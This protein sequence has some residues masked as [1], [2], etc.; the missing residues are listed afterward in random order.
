M[1]LSILFVLACSALTITAQSLGADFDRFVNEHRDLSF[2]LTLENISPAGT[3]PGCVIASPSKHT[4]PYYFHWVRDGALVMDS[5]LVA[6]E[7]TTDRARA[8]LLEKTLWDFVGMTRKIQSVKTLA[9]SDYDPLG[10]ADAKYNVDGSAY[11]GDWGRP[12]HDGPALRASS[13][14]RFAQEY[15]RRGGSID[16]VRNE[17]YRPALPADTPIKTDLELTTRALGKPNFDLWEEIMGQHFYTTIA[18]RRALLTGAKFA[19][20]MNDGGAGDWY[21]TK[22]KQ[23]DAELNAY[24][25]EERKY[26]IATR[27]FTEEYGRKK[28]ASNLDVAVMLGVLHSY[29]DVTDDFFAPDNDRVLAT[30]LRL[31]QAHR[32]EFPINTRYRPDLPPAIGRYTEDVYDGTENKGTKGNPWFLTTIGAA[33]LHYRI[34]TRAARRGSIAIS[35]LALPFYQD[36]LAGSE[37]KPQAGTF[38]KGSQEFNA[39]TRG[40]VRMGDLYLE[41]VRVHL[42][43]DRRMAEQLHRDTGFQLS[44][45]DLTWNYASFLTASYARD[46]ARVAYPGAF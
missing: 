12:Q 41:R 10:I 25:D 27:D 5:L 18:Q 45:S 40:L 34:V 39:I 17:L 8:E 2:K 19:R 3:H 22:A 23:L 35:Q 14:M 21:A 31:K 4:P 42:G 29:G 7:K 32:A 30:V 15:L 36:V 44:A 9:A 20:F 16:R 46:D 26:M 38:A 33:E 28:K 24:W 1:K 6:Y 37:F 43:P 13:L 11:M